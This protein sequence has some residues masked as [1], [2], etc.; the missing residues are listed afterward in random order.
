MT[1]EEAKAW[2]IWLTALDAE[3][4]ERPQLFLR[5]FGKKDL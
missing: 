5:M 1:P 3:I 4:A 2:R